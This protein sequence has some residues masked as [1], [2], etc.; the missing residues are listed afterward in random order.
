MSGRS[1]KTQ[2]KAPGAMDY[3][4]SDG[5]PCQVQD[6]AVYDEPDPAETDAGALRVE[7]AAAL[8]ALLVWIGDSKTVLAAGRRALIVS[9]AAGKSGCK[10]DAE[11][12][13]RLN[14]SKGRVSQLR[15]ELEDYSPGMARCNRRQIKP[16]AD[17]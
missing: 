10:S 1:A 6:P 12:A 4:D 5:R 16:R 2:E 14:I 9:H 3:F 7:F 11:L 15:A 8:A 17:R 13:Q